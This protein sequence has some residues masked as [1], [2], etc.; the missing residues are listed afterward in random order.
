LRHFRSVV[1]ALLLCNAS[2][3]LALVGPEP[4]DLT[5][6]ATQPD[7][8]CPTFCPRCVCCAQAVVTSMPA[9][10]PVLE[11]LTPRDA[12]PAETPLAAI[13]ADILHVPKPAR[14]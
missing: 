10:M 5:S 13:P 7:Q 6:A 11:R 9:P 14:R 12:I 3:L 1:I 8:Q 2:G 4:C